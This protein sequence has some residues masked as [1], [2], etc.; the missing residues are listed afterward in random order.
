MS[1]AALPRFGRLGVRNV[2]TPVNIQM[3][4]V[5]QLNIP[6]ASIKKHLSRRLTRGR[7][8]Q[9]AQLCIMEGKG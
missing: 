6:P 5:R 1:P 2:T 7:I 4:A 3:V 8:V 9:N